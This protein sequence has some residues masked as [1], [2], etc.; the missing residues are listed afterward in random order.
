MTA[1]APSL[2][3]TM[4]RLWI[5]SDLHLEAVAFPKAFKPTPPEFEVLVV[6]GDVCEGDT[7]KALHTVR[8]LANG[9]P[10]V[11]VMG[12]HEFWG[13]EIGQERR[14]A[15]HAAERHGVV[16]LEDTITELAGLRFVGGTLWADGALAGPNAKLS[17]ATE[18]LIRADCSGRP[19]TGADEAKLHAQTRREIERAVGRGE[20]PLVV[21]TH[22]APHPLCLPEKHRSGWAAGNAAS[23]LTAL[24]DAGRIALWVH[25]HVHHSVD[26]IRPGGTRII[27]NPAGVGF[28][29]LSFH[30]GLVI[31]V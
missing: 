22:H 10:A 16:L 13:R 31:E 19:I 27:C 20:A 7:D 12:N 6:A 14:A 21:V 8:R 11:F 23:D 1:G 26:L 17:L 25:G 30:D 4:P 15:R 18:E 5:M 29:N 3:V 28:A 9:K 24:T 2:E